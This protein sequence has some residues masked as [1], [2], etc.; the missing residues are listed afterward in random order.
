M[1]L[2]NKLSGR[3]DE[4]TTTE[5]GSINDNR[6][7]RVRVDTKIS[8]ICL[9]CGMAVMT[10]ECLL[11]ING[12]FSWERFVA[13]DAMGYVCPGCL[14][15]TQRLWR[16]YGNPERTLNRVKDLELELDELELQLQDGQSPIDT[17]GLYGLEFNV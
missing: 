9:L 12:N 15:R 4:A 16:A 14:T 17:G 6:S 1:T 5:E 11:V 8:T 10:G 7:G 3:E 2:L 13:E